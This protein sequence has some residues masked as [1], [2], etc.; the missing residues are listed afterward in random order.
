MHE[1]DGVSAGA[2][3]TWPAAARAFMRQRQAP[4]AD[5]PARERLLARLRAV[6]PV[7]FA[8]FIAACLYD[9]EVG[10]YTSARNPIQSA[11][12]GSGDYITSPETHPAFGRLLGARAVALLRA[13]GW[14]APVV[15]EAGAGSGALA[16]G[17]MEELDAGGLAGTRYLIIEPF[18]RWRERQEGRLRRWLSRVDWVEDLSE[19]AEGS[20]RGLFLANELMDA[21]PAHR[22]INRGGVLREILVAADGDRF[23]EREGSLSS[24]GLAAYFARLGFLPAP[25]RPVEV[26]LGALDS[27][28]RMARALAHG[29]SAI[30]LDYGGSAAEL[31]RDPER[32]GSLRACSRHQASADWSAR[33][34]AQDL[35]TD[36]DFTSIR[37]AAE[38][39]GL[40]TVSYQ[41]Q[42]EYLLRLGWR[43]WLA[44]RRETGGA[45]E[46][47][48]GGLLDL[49]DP[50]TQGRVRVLEMRKGDGDR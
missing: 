12:G 19:L 25:D 30:L 38:E 7:P 18:P 28:P 27:V 16:D 50:R 24:P 9:P 21:L 49:V 33:P 44:R 43:D 17:I 20:L 36:V 47:R 4:A 11:G 32:A 34:G 6:G 26:N 8:E 23:V 13:E 41:S 31:Y 42:R 10:Y 15:C 22:V 40:R 1:M 14:E 45:G 29:S 3:E 46:A 39:S 48:F 35:T 37:I 5:G 2:P